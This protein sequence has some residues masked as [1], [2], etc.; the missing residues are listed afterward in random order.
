MPAQD[1]RVAAWLEFRIE[2]RFANRA[3]ETAK[4]APDSPVNIHHI[5]CGS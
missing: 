2:G 1:V 3:M 5:L 4:A